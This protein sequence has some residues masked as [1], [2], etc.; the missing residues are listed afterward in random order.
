[1]ATGAQHA[2]S[3]QGAGLNKAVAVRAQR[4]RAWSDTLPLS[5]YLTPSFISCSATFQVPA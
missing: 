5:V 2:D 3:L 4:E 1:M